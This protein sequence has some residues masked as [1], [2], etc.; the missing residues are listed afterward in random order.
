MYRSLHLYLAMPIMCTLCLGQKR[1]EMRLSLSMM[2]AFPCSYFLEMIMSSSR[3]GSTAC[4]EKDRKKKAKTKQQLAKDRLRWLPVLDRW[5]EDRKGEATWQ[6][7]SR[8]TSPRRELKRQEMESEY[9]RKGVEFQAQWAEV[10]PKMSRK[11]LQPRRF[12]RR[13]NLGSFSWI[14]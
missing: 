1:Q 14:H 4:Q 8:S 13:N 6:R 10:I 12:Y 11:S 9:W 7:W 3:L 5:R 2:Q